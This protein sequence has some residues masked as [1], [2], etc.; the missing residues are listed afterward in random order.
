M[1]LPSPLGALS[2]CSSFPNNSTVLS[3]FGSTFTVQTINYV[4]VHFPITSTHSLSLSLSLSLSVYAS[5]VGSLSDVYCAVASRN[6]FNEAGNCKTREPDTGHRPQWRLIW[7]DCNVRHFPSLPTGPLRLS[8][9]DKVSRKRNLYKKSKI[10]TY[11][12]S[13]QQQLLP[14]WR[15]ISLRNFADDILISHTRD[16]LADLFDLA[17]IPRSFYQML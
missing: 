7:A 9:V 14:P 13:Q 3:G 6:M 15:A 1:I 4:S 11:V 17:T 5:P 2:L 10:C 8:T 16:M 12:F